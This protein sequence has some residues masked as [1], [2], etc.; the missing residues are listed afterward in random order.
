MASAISMLVAILAYRH[1]K[2]L[3]RK[4]DKDR[5]PKLNIELKD[6][7]HCYF[8]DTIGHFV[9]MEMTNISTAPFIIKEIHINMYNMKAKASVEHTIALEPIVPKIVGFHVYF[10]SNFV[11]DGRYPAEFVFLTD[12]NEIPFPISDGQL[13]VSWKGKTGEE[14]FYALNATT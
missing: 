14:E 3:E 9:R 6:I 4:M 7:F 11:L 8:P 5:E 13:R 12:K 2:E 1:S 10:S